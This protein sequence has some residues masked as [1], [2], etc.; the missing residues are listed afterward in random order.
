MTGGLLLA[1]T[2][3]LG[4]GAAAPAAAQTASEATAGSPKPPELFD[5]LPQGRLLGGGRLR[6]FGFQIY[7]ARLWAGPG[8]RVENFA[9]Q[10]LALELSYLRA[11]EGQAIA[12]RS[13]TEMRRTAPVSDDLAAQWLA[14]LRGVLPD[15]KKG[16]RIMGVHRPGVGASFWMNGKPM[17]DIRDAEFAKRFFGIWLAP[18]TSEPGLRNALVTGA[19]T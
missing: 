4:V 2:L 7:D 5:A 8:F 11:F 14:A 15:V 1:L 19:G 16:D 9:N 6:V 12:E 17:G 13:I 10:A 3:V 18:G